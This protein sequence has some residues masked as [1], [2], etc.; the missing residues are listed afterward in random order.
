MFWMN[1]YNK[2]YTHYIITITI[3]LYTI[4]ANCITF[5]QDVDIIHPS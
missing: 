5:I 1:R 2:D 3:T 4:M